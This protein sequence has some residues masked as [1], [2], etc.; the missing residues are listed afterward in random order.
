MKNKKSIKI[1]NIHPGLSVDCVLFGFDNN[2]LKILLLKLKSIEKWALPGGFVEKDKDVSEGT[3]S[4]LKERIGL[5]NIF[6]KQFYL[7]GNVSRNE[8]SHTKLL[9]E[10]K[11]I[12]EDLREWFQQ[13]FVTVGYYALVE[14]SK[15]K[16]T[17]VDFISESCEWHSINE[18]PEMILDHKKII[19]K[20]HQ[21]LK[22]ELNSE[23]IGLNLL[24]KQFT[25]PELQALYETVLEKKLDRR[26]FSRKMLNYRILIATNQRRAG[27]RHKAPKLYE[28]DEIKY[29]QAILDG[30]NSVW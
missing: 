30:F 3:N 23:P 5:E 8:N 19:L 6:L 17:T 2:E 22:K 9:I 7:F 1:E 21:T 27:V 15:V 14:Y 25:M 4:V 29:N 11:I 24:P 28:F 12:S 13:R 10:H 16:E 26:N 20:A 18:L